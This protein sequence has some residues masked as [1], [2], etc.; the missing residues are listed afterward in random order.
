MRERKEDCSKMVQFGRK[1]KLRKAQEREVEGG[2][3]K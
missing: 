1:E 2:W 3:E